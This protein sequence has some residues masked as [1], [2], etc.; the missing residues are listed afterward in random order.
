MNKIFD[1]TGPCCE[2]NQSPGGCHSE[3][4]ILNAVPSGQ[5]PD[6]SCCGEKPAS[7]A[8]SNEMPGYTIH[9]FVKTFQQT[10]AGRIPVVETFL[11]ARDFWQTALVR[12]GF[13]RD[14]YRIA[15][16]IYAVGEPGAD[17]PVLVTA[18]YK[19][20]FDHLRKELVGLNTWI[21]VLD[22]RGINVW[23]A[24]GK[25]TFS[26]EEIIRRVKLTGIAKLINHRNL[27]LPQLAATGVS[28][29]KAKKGCGFKVIWGPVKS[30]DIA[31]FLKSMKA[32]ESMRRITFSFPE[33]LVLVPVELSLLKKLTL[34]LIISVFLLSGISSNIFSWQNAWHRGLMALWAYLAGV[35]SGAVAVPALL[36]WL[37]GRAFSVKGA[38]VGFFA[39]VWVIIAFHGNAGDWE[40]V[41][42][43][44]FTI[45]ISSF[46]EIGRASCR[47]RVCHR[48]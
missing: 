28:G 4:K 13:G 38:V 7:K 35:F 48:V 34:Y 20:T 15:P 17:S 47:E 27:I 3:K 12:A 9:P 36:P 25:G 10:A 26:T 22:T 16:G 45:S 30:K 29:H 40:L 2:Q 11:S 44:L 24:A 37:P 39:A 42:L 41:A 5:K 14:S 43:F 8:S 32:G 18:N 46:L 1:S 33:R 21:L 31:A 19:L 6:I 23:C